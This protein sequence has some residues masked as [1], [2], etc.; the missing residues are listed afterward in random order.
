MLRLRRRKS[1]K[2][3]DNFEMF[4]EMGFESEMVSFRRTEKGYSGSISIYKQYIDMEA[5]APEVTG[6]YRLEASFDLIK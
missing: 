5:E 4:G 1:P 3:L 2:A 6:E